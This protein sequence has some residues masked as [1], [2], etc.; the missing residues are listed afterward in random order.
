[1]PQKYPNLGVAAFIDFYD[2]KS[3]I[4]ARDTKHKFGGNELRTNFKAK[5]TEKFDGI[6]KRTTDFPEKP[7]K[8]QQQIQGRYRAVYFCLLCFESMS[9]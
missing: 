3:A 1:M 7:S 8:G 6:K 4:E 9:R 2:V 5:T